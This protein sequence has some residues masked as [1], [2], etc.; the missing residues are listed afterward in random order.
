MFVMLVLGLMLRYHPLFVIIITVIIGIFLLCRFRKRLTIVAILFTL[1]GTGISYINFD[2]QKATYIGLIVDSRENYFLLN[3]S[4]EKLYVYQKNNNYEIGDIVSIEGYKSPISFAN[5]ESAF[6]F[7]DYLKDK[8]VNYQLNVTKIETKFSN[9]IRINTLKRSFLSHFK[10]E[11]TSHLVSGILFSDLG[12]DNTIDNIKSLHL[13]RLLSTSGIYIAIFYKFLI[14]LFSF[15]F[16]EKT[17]KILSFSFIGIYSIFVFPKFSVIRFMALTMMKLFNEYKFNKKYSYLTLLSISGFFFLFIDYHLTYSLSFI[18]GYSIPIINYFLT[19]FLYRYKKNNRRIYRY[20]LLTIFFVPIELIMYNEFSILTYPIQLLLTPLFLL[21][22]IISFISFLGLPIYPVIS[23]TANGIN[24]ITY[25][26]SFINF[27]IYAP[28]FNELFLLIYYLT[29]FYLILMIEI[30]HK[31]I[32]NL[33]IALY[34]S[35]FTLYL[36]PLRNIFTNEVVFINVGQGDATLIRNKFM[37]ILIDT[38]GSTYMDLA[39]D[40]LIPFLKKKQIY[41]I[42]LL[43]TTHDDYDHCGAAKSLISNFNVKNY[44]KDYHN[45]PIK[46]GDV[47]LKNY[48]IYNDEFKEEN[49][50]SLVIGFN[51]SNVNFLIT[52]DAPKKI[53]NRIMQDYKYIPCDILKVGHHGSNTSTS[54]TFINY[55]QPKEAII[56]CG[57]NNKY[58]HPHQVVINTLKKHHINIRRTDIEGSISYSYLA[59]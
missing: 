50:E 52:G 41:N 8:G 12:D 44:I 24:N 55:L 2:F 4:F 7:Q 40:S 58:G 57:K 29:Y 22:G 3:S 46:A 17:C 16:K 9:P 38:G 53:E 30:R 34:L 32:R 31:R 51:L 23:H 1:I 18:L 36:L 5:V 15:F 45:F 21:F 19:K 37:T 11:T 13:A 39:K 49:D 59:I 27:S 33:I 10:D 54:E 56:S 48:N 26:L 35:C 47:T 43:I 14:L 42:D 25:Y 6:S 20:I 28:P